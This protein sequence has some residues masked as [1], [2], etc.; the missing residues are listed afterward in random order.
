M[1]R[2]GAVRVPG[3]TL[4]FHSEGSGP[5]MLVLGS[6]TFYARA[7]PEAHFVHLIRDGRDVCL[8]LLEWSKGPRLA[9]RFSSWAEDAVSTT[10]SAGAA[11]SLGPARAR[12]RKQCAG[13]RRC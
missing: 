10:A 4:P 5:P 2:D 12:A 8:S 3:A 7:L 13:H 11:V 9:G 1:A 6:P